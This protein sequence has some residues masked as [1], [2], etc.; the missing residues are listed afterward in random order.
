MCMHHSNITVTHKKCNVNIHYLC[1]FVM[2]DFFK[3]GEN[4]GRIL[5]ARLG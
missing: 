2:R 5:L 1:I 3:P 4:E